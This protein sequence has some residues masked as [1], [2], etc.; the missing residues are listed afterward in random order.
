M[1]VLKMDWFGSATS[2]PEQFKV[3]QTHD[4]EAE[5]NEV[6][7]VIRFLFLDI[8]KK[9][10]PNPRKTDHVIIHSVVQVKIYHSNTCKA[11][12]Y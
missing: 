2:I 7:L 12:L 1:L 8:F 11:V 10:F 6:L 5:M 4:W 3:F 9:R